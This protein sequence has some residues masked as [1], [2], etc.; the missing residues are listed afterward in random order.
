VKEADAR[1]KTLDVNPIQRNVVGLASLA[2]FATACAAS[3]A[4]TTTTTTTSNVPTTTG[5]QTRWVWGV[6]EVNLGDGYVLGQCE[7]DANLIAC[8]TKR[9]P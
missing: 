7:G 4:H 2:L 3:P 8:F 1:R 5:V 6:D 9:A